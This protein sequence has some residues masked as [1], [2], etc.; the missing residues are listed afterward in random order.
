M[1]KMIRR[2][3]FQ[4]SY[5]VTKISKALLAVVL[6]Q[7]VFVR[8]WLDEKFSLTADFREEGHLRIAF[9]YVHSAEFYELGTPRRRRVRVVL[10]VD[11]T[12]CFKEAILVIHPYTRDLEARISFFPYKMQARLK[13]ALPDIN[14]LKEAVALVLSDKFSNSKWGNLSLRDEL[15]RHYLIRPIAPD[16]GIVLL[17]QM[18]LIGIARKVE[19]GEWIA[20]IT[21]QEFEQRFFDTLPDVR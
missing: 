12:D 21:K 3:E 11:I 15:Y 13:G 7:S 17:E 19:E 18:E 2:F 8:R 9:D 1:A 6:E 14:G 10:G 16:G 5:V 20:A 4:K